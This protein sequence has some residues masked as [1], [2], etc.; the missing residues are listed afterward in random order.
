MVGL[1]NYLYLYPNEGTALAAAGLLRIE[2]LFVRI[3]PLLRK[4]FVV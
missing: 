2:L 1:T 4:V 3:I